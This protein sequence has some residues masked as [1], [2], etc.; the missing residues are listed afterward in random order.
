MIFAIILSAI[1]GIIGYLFTDFAQVSQY[2]LSKENFESQDPLL[3]KTDDEYVKKLVDTCANGNG[4]FT[5][6][7]DGGIEVN[8]NLKSWE[9]NKDEYSKAKDEIN[10]G[11]GY[12]EKTSKLKDYYTSLINIAEKSLNLSY[13]LTN[14]TCSFAR[15]DKNILLNEVDDAGNHGVTLCAMSFLTGIFL[16]FSVLAGIL[17][18]HKF[19]LGYKEKI[20]N[21]RVHNDSSANIGNDNNATQP[22]M[23]PN[24]NQMVK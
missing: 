9:Q 6:V 7:I 5:N 16:G 17:L 2:V 8:K 23:F 10:C 14:V 11:T 22:N 21:I 18:V 1:F 13:S 24:N 20:S 19:K 15:N 4:N 3:F 12:E